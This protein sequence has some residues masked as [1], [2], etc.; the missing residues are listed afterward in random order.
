V[1]AGGKYLDPAIAGKALTSVFGRREG[2]AG[3][4]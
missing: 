4:L 2:S 3:G 1:A